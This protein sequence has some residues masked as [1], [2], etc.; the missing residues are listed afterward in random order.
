[1]T[2]V[3]RLQRSSSAP[4]L[5][6]QMPS[7]DDTVISTPGAEKRFVTERAQAKRRETLEEASAAEKL[8]EEQEEV[9][10]EQE[11]RIAFDTVLTDLQRGNHTLAE[12]L[13]HVFDPETKL[14]ADWRW[15]GFFFH[16]SKVQ[17][18]LDWWT[19]SRYNQTTR[20][21]VHDWATTLVSKTAATE[22]QSITDSGVLRKTNKVINE[23]F[24]L[25]F[26]LGGL[27]RQIRGMAPTA[28]RIFSA[29][30]TTA[31]QA[32]EMTAKSL[33]K[34]E[35]RQ[36]AAALTL[37]QASSQQNNYAQAV[38]SLYLAATGAQRQHLSVLS[39]YGA[40]INYTSVIGAGTTLKEDNKGRNRRK[41]KRNPGL[42]PLLNHACTAT[43]RLI[44]ASRLVK[45]VYDNLN[46]M[47]RVAEQILGRKNAQENGTCATLI[48]LYNAELEHLL[49]EDLDRSILEARLLHINDILLSEDESEFFR[50]NM[51]HTILRIIVNHGG[52]G[53]E[54]WMPDLAAAQPVSA[55]TIEVH[56]TPL[57]P[58]PT[59]EI[60]ESSITG[61]VEVMEAI[62][63]ILGF[64]TSDPE[65][66]K[67]IQIVAGDQLTIACQRSI[68]NVRLGHESGAHSWKHVVLMPGLFHAK[69][70]D[71]HGVLETHFGKVGAGTRSPGSLGFHNTVLDRLPITLTS[72]LGFR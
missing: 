11:K 29:F 21:F 6:S 48:P 12:F 45:L 49:T 35:L 62:N 2:R 3:Y 24:F 15:K 19:T 47:S 37:L 42:L 63:K 31:R 7:S 54:K 55:D 25:D 53:F 10:A 61:N 44:A 27:T 70:A 72:L 52:E 69:I 59:M 39:L 32:R 68:L 26:S 33:E 13:E 50:K 23:N 28:F 8:V 57:Y 64:D 46:I 43:F 40:S 67:Y 36:G 4:L 66:G 5:P 18:I 41:R 56:K 51:V 34:K 17:R 22:A 65:F 9:R 38:T 16:R 71:C 30:S 1:P 58:L 60:D 14:A 20:A